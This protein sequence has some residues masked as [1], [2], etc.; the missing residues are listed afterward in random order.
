MDPILV[1]DDDA[2]LHEWKDSDWIQNNKTYPQ[3]NTP[4]LVLAARRRVLAVPPDLLPTIF[5]D[6]SVPVS[7]LLKVALPAQ[8]S[9][10]SYERAEAAFTEE[11][12]T[13]DISTPSFRSRS[14]PPATYLA[15]LKDAFGQA[16]FDG[17]RSI[18]DF[19][20]KYSRLPLYALS[21]W[22]EMARIISKQTAWQRAQEWVT[23]WASQYALVDLAR[24]VQDVMERLAWGAELRALGAATSV[25]T[26]ALLLSDQWLDDELIDMLVSNLAVRAEQDPGLSREIAVATLAFHH[27]LLAVAGKPERAG[28]KEVLQRY[29]AR[30]LDKGLKRLYFLANLNNEHWVAFLIDFAQGTISYASKQLRPARL[31]SAISRITSSAIAWAKAELGVKLIDR[32]NCL[33]HGIQRD[34]SSC[35]VCTINTI[36]HNI[37]GDR[38]FTP[39][40]R[41]RLQLEYFVVLGNAQI[42]HAVSFLDALPSKYADSG[43]QSQCRTARAEAYSHS[44]SSIEPA[45][46]T[47]KSEPK[48]LRRRANSPEGEERSK[49]RVRSE[50]TQERPL[51][52]SPPASELIM[53]SAVAMPA[54][55]SDGLEKTRSPPQIPFHSFASTRDTKRTESA[56]HR[57]QEPGPVGISRSATA[58]RKLKNSLH[59]GTF[60][61]DERRLSNMLDQ[62]A[63]LDSAAEVREDANR[64]WQV[65]HSRC[66]KWYTMKEPYSVTRFRDHVKPS[67]PLTR[68]NT[69]NTYA[70]KLG[71]SKRASALV[72]EESKSDIQDD[73][74][75]LLHVTTGHN[76]LPRL[77]VSA[78][79]RRGP[80]IASAQAWP[81]VGLTAAAD[82][83]IP[84]YLRRSCV[85]GG[86]SRSIS[87]IA[88]KLYGQP[89]RQLSAKQKSVVDTAQ[90][91]QR[92]WRNDHMQGAVF[93]TSC[94]RFVH[95][96]PQHDRDP[97]SAAVCHACSA[98]L[99]SHAFKNALAYASKREH[100]KYKHLNKKYRNETLGA[101][102]ARSEGLEDLLMT[103]D[104]LALALLQGKLSG[105][106]VVGDI[107]RAAAIQVDRDERGVGRQNFQYGVVLTEFANMCAIAS[108][109]L[110][111]SLSKHLPLPTPRHLK[112]VQN[113]APQFPYSICPRT[114]DLVEQY[115]SKLRYTGPIALSCDDTKLHPAF[116]TYWDASK[117]VHM[118]VGGTDEPRA[119]A[120]VE[121]LRQYIDNPHHEKATK[122]RLWCAQIPL[123]KVPPII[124]AARAI[125]NSLSV[126]DLHNMAMQVLNGLLERGIPV[127]SYACDGTETERALQRR[128]LAEADRRITYTIPPP[129]GSPAQPLVV[130]ITVY[131][132][133]PIVMIQDSKHALKT[134]RNNLF[135]G[136]RLLV[137]GNDVAMYSFARLL[138]TGDH[139]P[140]YLRDIEKVDRQDD[141]AATR[142]FSANALEYLTVHHPDRVTQI[143][144]L[145]V[146]GEVV[147]AYQNR[148]IPHVERVK[149]VL[150]TRY[151]LDIWRAYLKAA[152]Y[153]EARHFISREAADI[154]RI[155]I[156]GLIGLIVI[157][158]FTYLDFLYLVPKLHAL[159]RSLI[160]LSHT[161]DPRA[162]AAGYAHTYFD[163]DDADLATLARF[164]TDAEIHQAAK[165]AWEEAESIFALLGVAPSDFI[166]LDSAAPGA[167]VHLPSI[168]AWFTPADDSSAPA[169]SASSVHDWCQS[170][171]GGSDLLDGEPE[172]SES[173]EEDG[174]CDDK[175]FYDDS[176]APIDEAAELQHL[177]DQHQDD[178]SSPARPFDRPI[179]DADNIDFSPM[180]SLRRQ[181]ETKRA[182]QSGRARKNRTGSEP[183]AA[184]RHTADGVTL[185]DGKSSTGANASGS[186]RSE[187]R[188]LVREMHALLRQQERGIGTGLEWQAR[189][190]QTPSVTPGPSGNTL[191]AAL[192]A[193][194]RAT[195]AIAQRQK[196]FSAH[197]VPHAE[198]LADALVGRTNASRLRHS[199]LH[200]SGCYGL[201]YTD[202]RVLVA[203][204]LA[205]Y[206]RDG[207]KNG[208][209]CWRADCDNIGLVSYISV[210]L[211]EPMHHT[212]YRANLQRMSALQTFTFAHLR[213]NH[214]LCILPGDHR[215]SRDGR[216]LTV[217]PQ[218][219]ALLQELQQPSILVNL[220]LAVKALG[221]VT[222]GKRTR[223]GRTDGGESESEDDAA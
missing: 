107:M 220:G 103:D 13:E 55:S 115:L 143:V 33:P 186:G 11:L 2:L 132:G 5:P 19:R 6:P 177:I 217:D 101:L 114:F 183:I 45:P 108:P 99:R 50:S 154:T 14:I 18:V 16:W 136:A 46:S 179:C 197:K 161:S 205:I 37:F 85:S 195:T 159:L 202:S 174:D 134:F 147:D 91:Q 21:Y 152:Q 28:S 219:A 216:Y 54:E 204:V 29:R 44:T 92:T 119:V 8:A 81:C 211:Y 188:E 27:C 168:S 145:F 185:A 52:A 123:P 53:R 129:P 127:R 117:Q 12:P 39:E 165:D 78:L 100:I 160:K 133:H 189:W 180:I 1:T 51:E 105:Y 80:G 218:N 111:R 201:V 67:K 196:I 3:N 30:V 84:L 22:E 193:G 73:A 206:T 90:T 212:Q 176:P 94:K 146:M 47:L 175:W 137:M 223:R 222:R 138:A 128:L 17:A 203:R 124:V 148:H 4:A 34:G 104:R 31:M 35:G 213:A 95:A 121:E 9:L 210:Q 153:P 66:G 76:D 155:L 113:A 199:L 190:M 151:F 109:E 74:R 221:T 120:N 139:S 130:S 83:R 198:I 158:D 187:Y 20:F 102:F 125:P 86:G 57:I 172:I 68:T 182:A 106:P 122:I 116:R 170:A 97:S 26:L 181:H 82:K 32:G 156:D 98:V 75:P 200:A 144:Y 149:M 10:L 38:L 162:R 166:H 49:K 63:L 112:R 135:S 59:D 89:Y 69:L 209:H 72:T 61:L 118:L 207:S 140:L 24:Q 169:Q 126:S 192:A 215:L 142:L 110:Y 36:A 141:N 131:H 65:W 60:E 70:H 191:N 208:K 184:S 157:K 173:D 62:V 7:A 93:S 40:D 41:Y 23:Q 178:W 56:A 42:T 77:R 25:E 167:E 71:W 58:S 164:P 43:P 64:R 79:S 48:L 96:R 88:K 194:Q 150:R 163:T 171:T 214:F 15:K 87:S